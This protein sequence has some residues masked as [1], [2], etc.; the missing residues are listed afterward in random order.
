MDLFEFMALSLGLQ[1][2]AIYDKIY[3]NKPG[4]ILQHKLFYKVVRALDTEGRGKNY[5][6]KT[7]LHGNW[8]GFVESEDTWKLFA[9]Q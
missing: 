2:Q 7:V 1:L 3:T 9:F 4:R 6:L 5:K 8:C